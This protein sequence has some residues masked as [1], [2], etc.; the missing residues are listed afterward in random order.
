MVT[1]MDPV[2]LEF[3]RRLRRARV[4][5][6]LTQSE[7]AGRL[8]L[9][10]TSITN[11]ERGTQPVALHTL[12]RLASAVGIPASDMLPPTPTQESRS[13]ALRKASPEDRE[14]VLRFLSK[15]L[16]PDDPEGPS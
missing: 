16:P 3:G 1:L 8:N 7:L 13:P 5:A 10:R 4:T 15:G 14:L 12:L 2:Y 6:G 9:S 11:M